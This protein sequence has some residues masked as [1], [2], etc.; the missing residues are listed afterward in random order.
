MHNMKQVQLLSW[1]S[2][3]LQ[4]AVLRHFIRLPLFL[5]WNLVIQR[6]HR[7]FCSSVC[8]SV[9]LS[10]CHMPVWC[11]NVKN[12]VCH[13]LY[14]RHRISSDQTSIGDSDAVNWRYLYCAALFRVYGQQR[15]KGQGG[16]QRG[17][18][19]QLRSISYE[20]R[21]QWSLGYWGL[22]Q[23]SYIGCTLLLVS[24]QLLTCS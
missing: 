1:L 3:Y 21:W 5:I 15:W 18:E 22:Q 24:A 13:L 12:F 20:G 17:R 19:R 8:L 23:G 4:A 9:C 16:R 7:Q 6:G 2:F 10:V 11:Q 14:P